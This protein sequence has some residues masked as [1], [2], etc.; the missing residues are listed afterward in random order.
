M[1]EPRRAEAH[2]ARTHRTA[3]RRERNSRRG[4]AGDSCA[5]TGPPEFVLPGTPNKST[6][7]SGEKCYAHVP[8]PA[9]PNVAN[10]QMWNGCRMPKPWSASNPGAGLQSIAR[11][12]DYCADIQAPRGP[13][14]SV[15]GPP[16]GTQRPHRQAPDTN[17]EPKVFSFRQ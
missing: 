5:A 6:V 14:T 17:C 15:N 3:S 12:H 16:V 11:S 4:K 13:P 8:N 7:R 10:G 1:R 2:A 9:G